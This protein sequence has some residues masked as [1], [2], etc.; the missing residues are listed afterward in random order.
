MAGWA[1]GVFT[2][3]RNWAQDKINLIN[4][5]ASLFDQEDD[6]FATG[7]N[8]CVT[9]DGTNKPSAVMD[10]NAQRLS[11]LGSPTTNGDAA[12]MLIGTFTGTLTGY[13][14]N[15]TGTVNYQRVGKIV[16]LWVTSAI[17]GTSNA[18]TMTMTGLPSTVQPASAV[19]TLC[20][21]IRSDA[22]TGAST[23]VGLGWASIN[24]GTIT[25]NLLVASG[26]VYYQTGANNF[27][28]SGTKGLDVGWTCTYPVS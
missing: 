28:A 15:P 20:P 19:S 12:A 13:A 22:T 24:A 21:G 3:A 5:Q 10:W 23:N 2:R 4:P 7:L 14:A 6:N 17:T 1:G 16:T 27:T 9:K 26:V 8:N 25:F 11:N 18:A